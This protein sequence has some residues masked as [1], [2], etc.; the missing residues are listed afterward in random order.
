MIYDAQSKL[1]TRLSTI[2]KDGQWMWRSA[3]S[4][5]LEIQSKPCLVSVGGQDTPQ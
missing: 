5:M 3:R 1:D 4:N 2:I